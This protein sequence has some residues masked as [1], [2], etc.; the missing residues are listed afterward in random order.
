MMSLK[1]TPK[2]A[3][4]WVLRLG[5]YVCSCTAM[6]QVPSDNPDWAEE[7]FSAA[8]A[9]SSAALIPIDMP[10]YVSVKVG[11]DP[12]TLTVGGDGVV[13]YVVVMTNATGNVNAAYEGI[14]CA[15]DE[16]KVYARQG[17]SGQW[18]NVTTPQW[19][20]LNDN[21]PS[22]HAYAIARQGACAVR[23]APTKTEV[24]SGLRQK[25]IGSGRPT[26]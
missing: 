14:R 9:F 8:P 26:F 12:V 5:L 13:R 20:G 1:S 3:L 4:V 21:T 23:L 15:T 2:L 25:Q 7:A 6:A 19:K 24:L 17:A 10:A 16:V 18:T 11:V 22:R